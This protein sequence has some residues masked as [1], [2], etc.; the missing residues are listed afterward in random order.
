MTGKIYAAIAEVSKKAGALAPTKNGAGV[1]FAFRG[2]DATV[3]HVAPFLKDAGIVIVPEVLD[4]IT[5]QREVGT[6]VVTQTDIR[7]AFH[8]IH[9]EDGSEVVATTAGLAQDFSDRSAAQAQSV[10]FRIAILQTFTLPTHDKEP[11]EVG[12][13]IQKGLAAERAK[14]PAAPAGP[15]QPTAS[16]LKAEVGKLVTNKVV[17]PQQIDA[18]GDEISGQSKTKWMNDPAILSSILAKFSAP[19]PA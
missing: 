6:K 16:Q 9:T 19:V 14:A 18:F 1:P 12:E 13:E 2:V 4:K 10:A 7:I 17:T 15:K 5:T 11:E 3:A 8:F